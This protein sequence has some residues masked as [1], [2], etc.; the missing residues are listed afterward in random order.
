[1]GG[2]AGIAVAMAFA[3]EFQKSR[4][5]H[6]H[7]FVSLANIYQHGHLES[8]AEML[9]KNLASLSTED[10]VARILAFVEHVQRED[11]FF[12][13]EHVKAEPQLEKE[14]KK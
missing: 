3:T 9:K 6:A 13:D 11:H 1:M 2:Y 7:G 10:M 14:W 4:P 12:D 5:P 8:I